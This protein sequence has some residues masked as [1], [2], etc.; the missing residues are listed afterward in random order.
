MVGLPIKLAGTVVFL[1]KLRGKGK[2]FLLIIYFCQRVY[3][4]CIPERVKTGS[5]KKKI[6]HSTVGCGPGMLNSTLTK[7]YSLISHITENLHSFP[8]LEGNDNN[9]KVKKHYNIGL[10]YFSVS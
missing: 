7:S 4:S 2:D 9:K 5:R 1:E 3:R 6:L 8:P 10:F